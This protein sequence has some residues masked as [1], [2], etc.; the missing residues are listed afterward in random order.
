M[1]ISKAYTTPSHRQRC[2]TEQLLASIEID[3]QHHF[4]SETF[5]AWT[6]S[7]VC[8]DATQIDHDQWSNLW[9]LSFY[10]APF[11]YVHPIPFRAVWYAKFHKQKMK[12]K[13]TDSD[14]KRFGINNPWSC[15]FPKY[16]GDQTKKKERER[17]ENQIENGNGNGKLH[18][19]RA[20]RTDDCCWHRWWFCQFFGT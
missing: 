4:S 16:L 1:Q 17:K 13:K 14:D 20:N 12:K 7:D 9:Q 19:R 11:R 2:K 15:F 5:H 3:S 6:L 10:L 8:G 18:G